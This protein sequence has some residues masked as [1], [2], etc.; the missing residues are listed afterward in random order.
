MSHQTFL[1]SD[2]MKTIKVNCEKSYD[3]KINQGLLETFDFK[4]L[5]ASKYVV[6]TDSNVKKL[7]GE[8]LAERLKKSGLSVNLMD[9]PAGEESK[10]WEMVKEIGQKLAKQN[11]N[12]DV[13]IVALGGGVVG[14]LAGFI[15][16]IYMRGVRYIHI[17]TTLLAQIDS[18]VGGK[19]AVNIPEGKNLL[20]T[21]HQ[22]Q[23]VVID[24]DVLN[25]LQLREIQNGLAEIIKYAVTQDKNL[26]EYLKK[27][28]EKADKSFY[29]FIIPKS[30]EIKANI[31]SQDEKEKELRKILNYGHTVG[32]AVE[33]LSEYKIPHG[34]AVAIGMVYEAK[35]ANYL[36]ILSN[37]DLQKQNDLIKKAKLNYEFKFD[38]DRAIEIMER[39]KKSRA[40]ELYFILPSEIGKIKEEKSQVAFPVETEIVRECLSD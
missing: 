3:I 40:K 16:S 6:I 10:N 26:F 7:Y 20:G 1:S 15:S 19:T 11:T 39:D 35:I 34:Q 30:V 27:N 2:E 32:H 24:P 25:T 31:I 36:G 4:G 37:E 17:P 18:S 29:E 5:N 8:K 9:F 28:I 23:V 14:D 21:F 13:I 22:P 38:I 12:R 33:I